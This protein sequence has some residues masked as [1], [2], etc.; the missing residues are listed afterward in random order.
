MN[1]WV[2]QFLSSSSFCC[3]YSSEKLLTICLMFRVNFLSLSLSDTSFVSLSTCASFCFECVVSRIV[4]VLYT[5]TSF[6]RV[7]TCGDVIMNKQTKMLLVCLMCLWYGYCER[8]KLENLFCVCVNC[9]HEYVIVFKENE[10]I[11]QE[12]KQRIE[13]EEKCEEINEENND[14]YFTNNSSWLMC[15]D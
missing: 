1:Q 14:K 7:F 4:A 10:I 15:E 5:R 11:E 13:K 8:L 6:S 9:T 12:K 2:S 3:C